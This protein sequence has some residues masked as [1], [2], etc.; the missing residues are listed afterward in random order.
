MLHRLMEQLTISDTANPT[1]AGII[2]GMAADVPERESRPLPHEWRIVGITSVAH[3]LCHV[4]EL[5]V[6]GMLEPLREEFHL[7]PAEVTLLPLTGY[8]LMGL[9]AIPTGLWADRWG[10]RRVLLIYFFWIAASAVAV[11]LA[12]SALLLALALT[13]LG[14]AA[15]LYHPAGL[16]MISHGCKLRGRALGINGVAGSVGVATG[17]ALGALLAFLGYW[18]LAYA[19][20]AATGLVCGLVMLFVPIDESASHEEP[21]GPDGPKRPKEHHTEWTGLPFLF[22]AMLLGG[23]NYRCLLTALPTFLASEARPFSLEIGSALT[24]GVLILGGLGQF[25]GGHTADKRSPAR[26]YLL[27]ILCTIPMALLMAHALPEGAVLAA[28]GVAIFMFAQQPV[29]NTIMSHVTSRRRRST[30]FGFKFALTFG[31]GALAAEAVGII[32]Q[33]TG[34][35]APAFDLFAVSATLMALCAFGFA[36]ARRSGGLGPVGESP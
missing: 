31:V 33:Q 35:L 1:L 6:V 8:V 23:F 25:A 36:R 26:L 28:A 10:S 14:A 13:S 3:A 11:S 27:L 29:E 4:S 30:F 9:G 34:S 21:D 19:I 7:Q 15:S 2:P 16:A 17:P 5:T 24:F 22:G 18:R 32:W 20:I 12:P